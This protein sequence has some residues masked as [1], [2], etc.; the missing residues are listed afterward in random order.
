M[1]GPHA[2]SIG[3]HCLF[4]KVAATSPYSQTSCMPGSDVLHPQAVKFD[5]SHTIYT[6][7]SDLRPEGLPLPLPVLS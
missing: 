7:D 4:G 2:V 1:C 6:S 3:Q 5:D